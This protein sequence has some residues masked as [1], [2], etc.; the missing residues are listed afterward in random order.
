MDIHFKLAFIIA[1]VYLVTKFLEMRFIIKENK[2]VKV[3]F[4]DSLL[5]YFSVVVGEFLL[6]QLTPLSELMNGGN[7]AKAFTNAPNF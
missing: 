6:G 1:L 2:E 7:D 4:R 5:V 3:L